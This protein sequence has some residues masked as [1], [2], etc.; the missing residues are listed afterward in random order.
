MV[1]REAGSLNPSSRL[2]L[3]ADGLPASTANR[4]A[5]H[6]PGRP[7]PPSAQPT[8]NEL[9]SEEVAAELAKTV[10]HI[11]GAGD[12]QKATEDVLWAIL[13]SKEFMFNH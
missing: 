8:L 6:G 1:S 3:G 5:P 4:P 10:I 12:K 13:N 7:Y 9:V 2:P 11:D